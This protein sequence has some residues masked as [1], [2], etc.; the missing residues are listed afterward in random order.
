[1]AKVKNILDRFDKKLNE[2]E[3]LE[4]ELQLKADHYQQLAD[5]LSNELQ[6]SR[7]VIKETRKLIVDS[8]L[9]ELMAEL[10]LGDH[11]DKEFENMEV[12]IDDFIE[13]VRKAASNI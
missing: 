7:S 12:E 2:V 11:I 9:G 8:P 1:M 4:K 3:E 13:Q 10:T 5:G 6:E